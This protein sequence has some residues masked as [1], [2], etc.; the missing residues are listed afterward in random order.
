MPE[1][2]PQWRAYAHRW[3]VVRDRPS[4]IEAA[5]A[6]LASVLIVI[7]LWYILTA[8]PPEERIID[9][10]TLPSLGDTLGSFPQLWFERAVA[11]GAI[12]SLGR[13]LGGF[14]L[15][16]AIA[17]PLGVLAGSFLRINAFLRPLSI[18]GRNIP[19]AALIL[20]YAYRT[21]S[22]GRVVPL[23]QGYQQ[24]PPPGYQP[25]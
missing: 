22:G 20:I 11:R 7:A 6:A 8:G 18:F 19:V 10:Y 2:K 13:V 14:L 16:A 21:L 23:D 15:A 24:G 25:S 17:I 12:W 1:S 4:R 9:A 5:A 3:L